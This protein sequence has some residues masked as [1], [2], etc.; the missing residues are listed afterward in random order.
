MSE[1]HVTGL[2]VP[3]RA[4]HHHLTHWT[5]FATN[6]I[7]LALEQDR[8]ALVRCLS[9]EGLSG[10]SAPRRV[11]PDVKGAPIQWPWQGQPCCSSLRPQS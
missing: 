5:F 9:L 2:H 1:T 4:F 8:S 7:A 11:T 10:V 3:P 6:R